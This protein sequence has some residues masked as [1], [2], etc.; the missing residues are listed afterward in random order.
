MVGQCQKGLPVGGFHWLNWDEA[1][2]W[3]RI[4]ESEGYGCFLEVDLEYPAELHD[5]HNDFPLVPETLV[6]NGFPKLTQNLMEKKRMVLH[7]ENLKQYLSLGMKLKKV[8]R[9]LMFREEA[10]MKPYIDKNTKLRME[11]K[12]AFEKDFFKLMNNSVFG[13]TMENIR[14]RV[15]I[16]LLKDAEKAEKLVNKPNFDE[17]RIFD[18]DSLFY[19]IETKDFFLDISNDVERWFD[20]SDYPK[21]HPSCIPVGKN[22]KV[23]GMFK[24]ECAGKS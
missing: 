2:R 17:L 23:I 20:T 10:F 22:K 6:L 12:N 4:V 8:W 3:E 15:N 1:V 18:E 16:H 19:E 13:K 24:D 7:G 14:N 11:A 21:D 9:V 5:W